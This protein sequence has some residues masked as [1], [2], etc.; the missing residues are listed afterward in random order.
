MN[1]KLSIAAGATV[2]LENV[3]L[4]GGSGALSNWAGITCEGSATIVLRGVN[5]ISGYHDDYPGIYVPEGSTLTFEGTG[6]L[7]ATGENNGCGIGNGMAAGNIVVNGGSIGAQGGANAAGI[8]S[9]NAA[10]G[11]IVI[12]GG[13]VTAVGRENAAGIGS[14]NGGS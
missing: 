14:G 1:T 7:V 13:T 5:E 4:T 12:N 10:V 2:V 3:T 8:G 11:N 9:A 6:A